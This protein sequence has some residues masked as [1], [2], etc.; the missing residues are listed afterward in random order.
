MNSETAPAV[1]AAGRL[2][3]SGGNEMNLFTT[4]LYGVMIMAV[5]PFE[6]AAQD[7]VRR[8]AVAGQFYEKNPD[9]LRSVVLRYLTDGKPLPEPARMLISPHA[10]YVFSGSVAG[11]GYAT[12]DN[13]ARRVIVIGP[14]HHE[15]FRGIAVPR[16]EYYATP[17]G[18]V[19]I[20]RD[21]VEKLLRQPGVVAADGFDE[22]EHSLEVQLPFLQV[23]L[24][25]FTLVP[26][27]TGKLDPERVAAMLAPFVDASTLVIASSDLSHY[28]RQNDAR[29]IDDS[30]IATIMEG[31]F[32]GAIEACGEA[33][34]R[35][36]MW[37][38]KKLGM[39]P[40]KIDARTSFDTAPRE[41]PESRVVGYAA[42]AYVPDKHHAAVRQAVP[43][44][45][46]TGE[47]S[48][49]LKKTLLG[50]ARM[51]LDA[52]VKSVKMDP[53]RGIP[54]ELAG[55]SGCFVTLTIGGQLRGCI[56]Y[57]EPVKP[58]YQAVIENAANAAL[59]DPRFPPVRPEELKKIKVEV[60]VL[61]K[62]VPLAF[63]EPA[64]L[65]DKLVPGRDGVI[66]SR[67]GRQSTYLPQVWAQLPDKEAF[68]EQLSIKGGMPVDGWKT[69]SV[70]TYRA[71]HFSE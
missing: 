23:Q 29:S 62:P 35:I 44:A 20:D 27:I 45:E 58:L 53:P 21:M 38:A 30:T 60:S 15:A 51:S 22:P 64:D 11:K 66:L 42:I 70:K 40:V 9:L 65:L 18:K 16:W 3:E 26:V 28:K 5:F 8:P 4:L 33:P 37:L 47:L 69:A 36:V 48:A 7:T 67:G 39:S 10:G 54:E 61:T 19:K 32:G 56:G 31:N 17:L 59:N 52:A 14:S 12:I 43:A 55:N 25:E 24:N 1:S 13:N 71:I 63:K 46:P 68:L 41:C 34:I 50:F 2:P 49:E 57:I 6:A